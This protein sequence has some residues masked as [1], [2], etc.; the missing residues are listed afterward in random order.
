MKSADLNE[1]WMMVFIA[2]PELHRAFLF[3]LQEKK[4]RKVQQYMVEMPDKG[5][6]GYDSRYGSMPATTTTPAARAKKPPQ[7]QAGRVPDLGWLK[8][9]GGSSRSGCAK[10]ELP[11]LVI[12]QEV[13]PIP[14]SKMPFAAEPVT[15]SSAMPAPATAS[16]QRQVRFVTSTVPSNTN[17][18]NPQNPTRILGLSKKRSASPTLAQNKPKLPKLLAKHVNS[19]VEVLEA[20]NVEDKRS[21]ATASTKPESDDQGNKGSKVVGKAQTGTSTTESAEAKSIAN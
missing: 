17:N 9:S 13:Q 7:Q 1:A 14:L 11:Q 6:E 10:K 4:V 19:G 12:K 18:S 16:T 2:Y 5:F 21:T 20:K 3:G 15:S 8:N